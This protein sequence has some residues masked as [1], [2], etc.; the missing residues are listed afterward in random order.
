MREWADM[1]VVLAF[2]AGLLASAAPAADAA[3]LIVGGG[4]QLVGASGVNV[5]GTL[6]NVEFLDGTCADLFSGCDD[7]G[8]FP[9]GGDAPGA[10]AAA[11][12]LLDQVFIDSG[13]GNFDSNPTLTSGCSDA[14]S[15]SVD[16]PF[17]LFAGLVSSSRAT[18]FSAASGFPDIESSGSTFIDPFEDLTLVAD[19][20]YARFSAV[21]LPASG[22]LLL[23]GL[24]GL[25]VGRRRRADRSS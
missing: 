25:R 9:F 7:L 10:I 11:Q 2:V 13:L 5:N 3:N 22:L 12:A 20:V 6:Y 4:G 15:C 14:E 1:T 24:A 8:D 23:A 17:A 16:F 18:N 19:S 21:P